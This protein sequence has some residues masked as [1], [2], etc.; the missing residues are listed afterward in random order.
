MEIVKSVL[1]VRRVI[2]AARKSGK[3]IGFIPTMGALHE[4]HLSLIR[5][6]KKKTSLAVVSI[7]VN[8]TQFAPSEDLEKYPRPIEKDIALLEKEN[9][10]VLFLPSNDEIYPKGFSTFV[11]VGDITEG[12]EGLLRP[13]HFR[14][15]AT[16]VASL[17]NIIQPDVAF[18]GQK[19]LQQAAVIKRMVRDLHFPVQ[20]EIC[21]TVREGDGLAMSSRNRYLD[22]QEREEALILS[23][24][25]LNAQ[26]NLQSGLSF[27]D[28]KLKG[29]KFFDKLKKKA[30]LEYLDIINPET[31]QL[32][33]SFKAKE[34]VAIIIAA[35][36]GEARLID[37]V[38]V[39]KK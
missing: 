20:I 26:D 29:A 23:Q 7:Y 1:E 17:F 14:G 10:D 37:N 39:S 12:F 9:T 27:A 4:G 31:F 2:A 8:P 22:L 5:A 11:T 33:D 16:V 15:V 32:A 6:S 25:L 35:R 34:D 38:L 30:I 28:V 3:T 18:F 21:K 36:I 19:D 13:T 24:T